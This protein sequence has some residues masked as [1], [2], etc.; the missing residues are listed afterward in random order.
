MS[1]SRYHT[2][3]SVGIV[4]IGS[5]MAESDPYDTGLQA[6][7]V[8]SDVRSCLGA[9]LQRLA[10]ISRQQEDLLAGLE[11]DQE[12]Y[13]AGSV[14]FRSGGPAD[15]LL[16]LK[17]GWAW[18]ENSGAGHRRQ[19]AE[20]HHP[21]DIVG[22]SHLPFSGAR[23]DS[24]AASQVT[25]CRFPRARLQ[26]L[27]D[28]S[29]RLALMLSV[30][31]M[32]DHALVTDRV[33]IAR[34]NDAAAKLA[35]FIMQTFSRLKLMNDTLYDQFYC[36]LTLQE[37]GD[38]VGLTMVHV[39]RVFSRLEAEGLAKRHKRFI[40]ILDAKRL[41]EIAGFSDRYRDLDLEW[42]PDR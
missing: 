18:A 23:H 28:Q 25:V 38:V 7:D 13:E 19:I 11:E 26:E 34:R 27:A 5:G 24:I 37:I 3:R 32:I 35:L 14:L 22:I 6:Q 30:V 33:T 10:P 21:G 17:R 40:R 15:E 42:L 36:P 8:C 4:Q 12:E 20:I 29:P 31:A 2:C 39:S 9:K 16:I 1:A 41:G